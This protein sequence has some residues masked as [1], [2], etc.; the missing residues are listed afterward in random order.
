VRE[1][2]GRAARAG[3]VWAGEDDAVSAGAEGIART[4]PGLS[5]AVTASRFSAASASMATLWRWLMLHRLSP[6]WIVYVRAGRGAVWLAVRLGTAGADG[7]AIVATNTP[8]P[9]ETTANT[10]WR[11]GGRIEDDDWANG[12]PVTGPTSMTAASTLSGTAVLRNVALRNVVRAG[13]GDRRAERAR[14][15]HTDLPCARAGCVRLHRPAD[16]RKPG[17]L[18]VF[19]TRTRVPA[20][21]PFAEPGRS[22][23]AT[24]TAAVRPSCPRCS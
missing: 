20:T 10:A 1:R 23:P 17:T 11:A 15:E 4:V 19:D 16:L 6:S 13:T 24:T 7:A 22:A 9:A 3:L 12:V 2:A 18:R 5:G 21:Q 8:G 14:L